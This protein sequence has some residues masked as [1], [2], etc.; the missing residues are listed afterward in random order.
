MTD[1]TAR[2]TVQGKYLNAIIPVIRDVKLVPE[3]GQI[4]GPAELARPITLGTKL[5]L[6]ATVKI[7]DLDP[8]ITR[9]TDKYFG[10]R[11]GDTSRI[12]ELAR[13]RTWFA[14]GSDEHI[15]GLLGEGHPEKP[16]DHQEAY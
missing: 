10:I 8:C 1:Y 11:D 12:V 7:K 4:H 5:A 9:I 15:A 16:G 13:R 2:R 14:P 6:E 3:D